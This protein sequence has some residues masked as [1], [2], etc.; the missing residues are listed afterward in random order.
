MFETLFGS[1]SRARMI[2]QFE[3]VGNAL[4]VNCRST[5]YPP[6]TCSIENCFS[7]HLIKACRYIVWETCT[8]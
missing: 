1:R 4:K 3:T 7:H 5:G 2:Q 6:L 8:G